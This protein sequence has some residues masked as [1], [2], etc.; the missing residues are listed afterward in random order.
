M[1]FFNGVIF[2]GEKQIVFIICFFVWGWYV[3]YFEDFLFCV[4]ILC[5]QYEI[6]LFMKYKI[7]CEIIVYLI[8]I[9]VYDIILII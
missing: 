6:F 4:V 7:V 3:I 9:K 2:F 1:V 8:I 5:I